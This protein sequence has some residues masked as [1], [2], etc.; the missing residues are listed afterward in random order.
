MQSLYVNTTGHNEYDTE[1]NITEQNKDKD[2]WKED[3]SLT[4]E[5]THEEFDNFAYPI[6][7]S[8][9][10]CNDIQNMCVGLTFTHF[11][12]RNYGGF[13]TPNI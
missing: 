13:K 9:T 6:F 5:H 1:Q 2:I 7:D 8:E 11:S 3:R 12:Y 10:L 4:T